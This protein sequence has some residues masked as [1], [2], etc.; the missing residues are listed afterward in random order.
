[1]KKI[2]LTACSAMILLAA[3]NSSD[4]KE[5]KSDSASTTTTVKTDEAWVPVDSATMMK[6]MMDVQ[7]APAGDP[8]RVFGSANGRKKSTRIPRRERVEELGV[9]Y[10]YFWFN[11]NHM[12]LTYLVFRHSLLTFHTHNFKT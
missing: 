1:M 6:A 5:N 10:F 8:V 9:S 3:C 11:G 12:F 4:T 2:I 7:A